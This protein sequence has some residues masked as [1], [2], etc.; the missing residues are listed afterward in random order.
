MTTRQTPDAVRE[1]VARTIYDRNPDANPFDRHS[2]INFAYASEH[3][4]ARAFEMADAILAALDSRAGD[5]GEP[6]AWCSPGQLANLTD[7]D[8]DGGVYLPIRKTKRGNFTMPLFASAAP[9]AVNADVCESCGFPWGADPVRHAGFC[10]NRY[11]A[12]P[13]PA[14]DAV[15]AWTPLDAWQELSE[16]TDR[17]SPA[18]YPDMC[19]ITFDELRMFMARPQPGCICGEVEGENGECP[20]HS[21]QVAVD[22]VPA[23]EV[24]RLKIAREAAAS[25][26]DED[27]QPDL[28]AAIRAGRE[29]HISQVQAALAALSHGEG[30]K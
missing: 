17:T 4:R 12:T 23:G 25:V 22:A 10:D 3:S 15:Q 11:T 18:E 29:D 21:E 7:V 27:D 5:A 30:R 14:V 28:A 19:L 8:R 26:F 24:E 16:Y 2:T 6:V 1:A 20:L 13:A 9:K